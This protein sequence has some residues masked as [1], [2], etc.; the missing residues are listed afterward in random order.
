M[1][2]RRNF[3]KG[4]LQVAAYAQ[5]GPQLFSAP[6]ARTAA[7][8]ERILVVLQ[9][10]GGNDGIGTLLPTGQD[11][12]Y[13][14]RPTLSRVAEGAHELESGFALH[15]SLGGLSQ[16]FGEGRA[17]AVHS[18]G[19]E[20]PDRSHFRSMEIWH[21][22][23]VP[24]VTRGE[25]PAKGGLGWLGRAAVQLAGRHRTEPTAVHIGSGPTPLSLRTPDA[26]AP[27][28]SRVEDLRLE[29]LD[30]DERAR[31]AL[32]AQA[33]SARP[34]SDLR[35]LRDTA[36]QAADLSDRLDA[37]ANRSSAADWP[38]TDLGRRLQLTATLI[39][40]G[41]GASIYGLEHGSFDTHLDQGPTHANLLLDLDRCLSAFH[42]ELAAAG[43]ADR[44]LLYAFS[45]FGRRVAENGTAGTD[46]GA[47]GPVL[48][49]GP[50]VRPGLHGT[51]PDLTRLQQG[52]LPSTTDFRAIH[53]ALEHHWL[54]LPLRPDLPAPLATLLT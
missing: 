19:Y 31:L 51:P 25:S 34:G 41:L 35:F 53:A 3:I 11:A 27:S 33:R 22:G 38:A 18:V 32:L 30:D 1:L 49:F 39:T 12:W 5:L 36:R 6:S 2:N 15:P 48:L 28:L 10:T 54:G 21:T 29:G 7:A 46:H 17:A 9:L 43:M 42:A 13:R 44:V 50:R 14:A 45:E 4:G 37:A 47:A 16:A 26:Q 20:N 8:D 52:D 40:G 24:A 23:L